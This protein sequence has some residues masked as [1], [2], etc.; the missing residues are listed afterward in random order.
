L[1]TLGFSVE[2]VAS[3]SSMSDKKLATVLSQAADRAEAVTPVEP[4]G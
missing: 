3:M 2:Q 4:A 1:Q